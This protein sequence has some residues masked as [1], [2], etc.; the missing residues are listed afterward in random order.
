MK[1]NNKTIIHRIVVGLYS[2]DLLIFPFNSSIVD[3]VIPHSGQS[4]FKNALKGHIV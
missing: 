4:I 1:N 2:N 3:L